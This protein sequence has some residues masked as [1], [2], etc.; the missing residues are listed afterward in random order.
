M[1]GKTYMTEDWRPDVGCTQAMQHK[2]PRYDIEHYIEECR[3]HWLA[4]GK[5]MKDWNATF[6]NWLRRAGNFGNP[7][8]KAGPTHAVRR[9]PDMGAIQENPMSREEALKLFGGK[10]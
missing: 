2:Y 6:R 1:K 7:V 9:G 5:A 8:L 3:D 4:N 10:K